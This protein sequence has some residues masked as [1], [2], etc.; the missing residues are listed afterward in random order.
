MLD[1]AG[2]YNPDGPSSPY[3]PKS[4]QQAPGRRGERPA[5]YNSGKADMDKRLHAIQS[6]SMPQAV[7]FIAGAIG[8]YFLYMVN[9]FMMSAL[10][11]AKK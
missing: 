8:F 7:W 3:A 11:L 1:A 4:V 9:A 6:K 5:S 2:T 10:P